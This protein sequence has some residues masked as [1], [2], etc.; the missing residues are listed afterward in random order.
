MKKTNITIYVYYDITEY[1]IFN[2]YFS[3]A[4]STNDVIDISDPMSSR[5]IKHHQVSSRLIMCH[6][7]S[8]RLI[9]CHQVSSFIMCHQVSS[10]VIKCH[11]ISLSIIKMLR[12]V[13]L[14]F[15]IW[16]RFDEVIDKKQTVN[17]S[18][19]TW[20]SCLSTNNFSLIFI[21]SNG[22]LD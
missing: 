16:C 2:K 3:I 18:L 20:Y 14:T 4:Q 13:V 12:D 11:Q 10:Y 17:F 15:S 5:V 22:T 6:K 19:W 8:S 9:K 7:V 1:L 21:L